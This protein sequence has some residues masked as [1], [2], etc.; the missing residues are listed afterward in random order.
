MIIH[1]LPECVL[2]AWRDRCGCRHRVKDTALFGPRPTRCRVR[3][4]DSGEVRILCESNSRLGVTYPNM[5]N[6]GPRDTVPDKFA[7][8]QFYIH[9]PTVTLMRTTREECAAIGKE[10]AEKVAASKGPAAI[11]L[12]L[13]GVSA[14]DAEGQPFDAPEA[15]NALFDAIRQA[16]GSVGLVEMPSHIN[17]A[18]FAEAAARRLVDIIRQSQSHV[19]S[20]LQP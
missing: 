9:N 17:D 2:T 5:V 12:P 4:S 3:A 13:K 18:E 8:R 14:I 7:D 15:R 6:F 16:H 1:I 10:I 20:Q 19:A 11:Y